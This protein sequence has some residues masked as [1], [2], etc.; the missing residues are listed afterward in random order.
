M[1]DR[2][3][4]TSLLDTMCDCIVMNKKSG[5]YDGAY[6]VVEIAMGLKGK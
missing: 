3:M 6:K 4:N 1:I 5:I 2:F